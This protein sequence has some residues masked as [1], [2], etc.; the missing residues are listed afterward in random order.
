MENKITYEEAAKI[1]SF[2]CE[3]TMKKYIALGVLNTDDN[4][5]FD[6]DEVRLLKRYKERGI[7]I[8]GDGVRWLSEYGTINELGLTIDKLKEFAEN[9]RLRSRIYKGKRQYRLDDVEEYKEVQENQK[10][11]TKYSLFGEIKPLYHEYFVPLDVINNPKTEENP[12]DFL[13]SQRYIVSNLGRVF[14]IDKCEE[15]VPTPA[16]NDYLQVGISNHGKTKFWRVHRLVASLFCDNGKYK[17]KVH[18]INGDRKDNRAENLVFVNDEEHGKAG[19]LLNKTKGKASDSAEKKEYDAYIDWLREDNKL[20]ERQIKANMRWIIS[21]DGE[22]IL[23]TN[24]AYKWL[25]TLKP[26][27]GKRMLDYAARIARD[28]SEA[29]KADN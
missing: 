7:K 12:Q 17:E 28:D 25:N 16:S 5:L 9:G 2:K 26:N 29:A 14:N 19:S 24:A 18:H 11:N 1:L 10:I 15:L 8:D 23:A 21:N 4:G 20:S 6:V 22:Y 13:T 3:A 27:V